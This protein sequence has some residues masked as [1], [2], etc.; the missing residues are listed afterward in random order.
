M[1][2]PHEII[3]IYR[4]R[5]TSGAQSFEL[6]DNFKPLYLGLEG[7]IEKEEGVTGT[8]YESRGII[9]R[10]DDERVKI[11]E[12]PI[13]RWTESYKNNCLSDML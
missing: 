9:R 5:L 7:E 8:C 12:L 11:T 2:N 10:L 4:N 1:F 13:G 6:S 3:E